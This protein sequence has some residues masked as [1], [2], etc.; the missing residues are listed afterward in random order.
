MSQE[1]LYFNTSHVTVYQ[2]GE[3][4]EEEQDV[5]QYISCYCLSETHNSCANTRKIS[6]HLMLLFIWVCFPIFNCPKIISIHLMLLF[7][8]T[9]Y[10]QGILSTR[11]SIHLMLLFIDASHVRSFPQRRFQYISCY[12]LSP[13]LNCFFSSPQTFQYISCY[14]LSPFAL[15]SCALIRH[16]NTSHVTVYP[17]PYCRKYACY[18][19]SI[20]LMLLFIGAKRHHG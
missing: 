14:C 10:Q 5:F 16:F 3:P 20:H 11:I 19:I 1:N 18:Y 9:A 17:V 7:I 8:L 13:N 4:I 2:N 12:C 6:I 15:C